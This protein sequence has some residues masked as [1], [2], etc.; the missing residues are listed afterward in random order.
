V[1]S[2]RILLVL[3]VQLAFSFQEGVAQLNQSVTDLDSSQQVQEVTRVTKELILRLIELERFNLHYRL[4]CDKQ[5]KT[6]I[7]RFF[8]AHETN[9]ALE[10]ATNIILS[11]EASKGI[12]LKYVSR[13]AIENAY[14]CSTVGNS[15]AG[16]ASFREFLSDRARDRRN[17][18][19]GL[20]HRGAFIHM[21]KSVEEIDRLIALRDQL[22]EQIRVSDQS[23]LYEVLLEER[24][25]LT[26]IRHHCLNEF[27]QFHQN[28]IA[29]STNK[30]VFYLANTATNGV[31]IAANC[32]F[33]K[34]GRAGRDREARSSSVAYTTMQSR[35]HVVLPAHVRS[36]VK[37]LFDGRAALSIITC[38][39]GCLDDLIC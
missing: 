37:R 17:K 32:L 31:Y 6:R 27:T 36:D 14:V 26:D 3:F 22:I 38:F 15:V 21:E 25:C 30:D 2:W 29:H 10:T 12:G 4:T 9:E 18:R 11:V 24:H 16:L 19:L 34:A 33:L 7:Y 35:A 39:R 23:Q 20:D 5:P 28:M 1:K 8:A 13:Q